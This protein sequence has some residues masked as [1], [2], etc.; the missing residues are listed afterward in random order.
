MLS[1]V[2]V[3]VPWYEEL[4]YSFFFLLWGLGVS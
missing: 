4:L 2:D 3:T 1:K